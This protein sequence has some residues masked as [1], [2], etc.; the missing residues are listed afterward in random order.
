MV[1]AFTVIF[2]VALYM[3]STSTILILAA[4]GVGAYIYM[5]AQKQRPTV[6]DWATP[7]E[8]RPALEQP[9]PRPPPAFSF[10][11]APRPLFATEDI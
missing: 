3:S 2:C 8:E 7:A 10:G 4:L 1:N 11:P 9:V 5:N 6:I